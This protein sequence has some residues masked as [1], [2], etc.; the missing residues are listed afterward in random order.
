M[1]HAKHG[2]LHRSCRVE[3][4]P[5]TNGMFRGEYCMRSIRPHDPDYLS[6]KTLGKKKPLLTTV[7]LDEVPLPPGPISPRWGDPP[8]T[9]P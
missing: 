7:S 2:V 1:Y 6:L 8:H 5:M 3:V 4:A 9:L